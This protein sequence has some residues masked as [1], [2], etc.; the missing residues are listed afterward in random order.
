MVVN[1]QLNAPAA[2]NRGK[3]PQYTLGRRL[4]GPQDQ[5]G[6]DGIEKYS[7]IAPTGNPTQ[8]VQLET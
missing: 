3:S 8:L 4:G 7:I 2:S 6:W 1:Y 5:S